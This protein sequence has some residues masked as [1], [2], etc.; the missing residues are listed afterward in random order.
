MHIGFIVQLSTIAVKVSAYACF[1]PTAI[2]LFPGKQ[3]KKKKIVFAN[4]S[5]PDPSA[6]VARIYKTK[7]ISSSLFRITIVFSLKKLP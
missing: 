4:F 6:E 7:S 3:T 1:I 2:C 5:S